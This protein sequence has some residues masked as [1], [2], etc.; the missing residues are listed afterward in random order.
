MKKYYLI[1]ASFI[2]LAGL[3]VPLSASADVNNFTITN[4][5]SDQTFSKADPQGELHIIE[6]ISVSFTDYNHGILRAIP[7]RYKGHSL[8]LHINSIT[9]TSGAASQYTTYSSNGNTV[10]KIGDPNRT[11]TGAQEYTID[12]SLRN[13]IS[14]YNNYDE[15]YW[16]VN[17]DQWQQPFEQVS[18]TVH[19]PAGLTSIKDPICYTG[20][21]GATTQDCT[22]SQISDGFRV[23]T[24]Q[25]LLPEQTLTYV[26]AFKQGYFHPSKWYDTLSEYQDKAIEFILPVIVVGGLGFWWWWL[27]GRDPRGSGIIIPQY[28]APDGLKPLEVGTL[29]DFHTD[30]VDITATIVDLAIRGYLKII[31]TTKSKLLGKD[32]QV[33]S[34]ELVKNDYSQLNSHETVLMQ[35]LFGGVTV[36]QNVDVSSLKNKLYQTANSLRNDVE[37]ALQADGYM[38]GRSFKLNKFL[39][40]RLLFIVP[41]AIIG[42]STAKTVWGVAGLVIGL[43]IFVAFVLHLAART[44]KGV[45]AL[46]HIKGLKLYLDVAEKDR[47]EKLQG[48]NAAYAANAGEPV[49]TVELFEKLLPYAM[50]LGVEKQWAGQFE[51]LYTTPPGWYSGNWTTFNALYFTSNLNAGLGQAI[52][53]SFSPPASSG[54]SGFGGGG[55]SGGGG[56]GGGGGGW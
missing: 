12:Y 26:A 11:F 19:L 48:P 22:V 52:N 23:E 47:L 4:F 42:F 5:T 17:G 32:K 46:E 30:N 39:V 28:D 9:S 35:A 7:D 43:V 13:V 50:V 14:F 25:A 21:F 53:A 18:V 34:L 16:D 31:E 29:Q 6:R 56:G 24:T 8:Q 41:F 10:L 45:T 51:S 33:Y 55:F 27:R 3:A 54:S 1:V 2:M 44:A 15:L 40:F 49:K 37:T 20:N 36:G 38:R